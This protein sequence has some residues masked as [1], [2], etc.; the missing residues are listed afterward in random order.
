MENILPEFMLE[1]ERFIKKII[2]YCAN[3]FWFG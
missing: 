2:S 1:D 3:N